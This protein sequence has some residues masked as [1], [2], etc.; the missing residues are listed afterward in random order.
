MARAKKRTDGR[1]QKSVTV[2]LKD[3]KPIRKVVYGRT[4]KE[5]DAA[6][7]A[8]KAELNGGADLTADT[9]VAELM[10]DYMRTEK[11]SLKRRAAESV[12]YAGAAACRHVG[13]IQARDLTV[14]DV[15]QM[16]KAMAE[17]P[18]MFNRALLYLKGALRYGQKRGLVSRNVAELVPP[19]RHR[20]KE[21]RAFTPDEVTAL[22]EADLTPKER[23]LIDILY[24][25]GVRIGECLAL[26][27]ADFDMRN[28]KLRINK[29]LEGETKTAA[30]VRSIPIAPPLAASLRAYLPTLTGDD[31]LLFP[32]Q[33]GG[34]LTVG[35][36]YRR[37]D[38]LREKVFGS[39]AA[40]DITP[41]LFRHN[42]ASDLYKAGVD[43]KSAQYLL[44]HTDVK[45]TLG[46]YTHFGEG[47][48]DPAKLFDY[49]ARK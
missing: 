25:T 41:H 38:R 16:K 7:V 40:E 23:A 36:T 8:L 31:A 26:T 18:V 45:T 15:E 5:L 24:Y 10:E 47:D 30:G 14:D 2:G 49:Y 4:Q 48:I 39:Y 17:T 34:L 46:I 44:G 33:K 32:N 29:S 3:G 11:S 21:K 43:L 35:N 20:A 28:G 22:R 42:Y 19:I 12:K 1:Y 27:K 9:T 13:S 6:Y 37:W